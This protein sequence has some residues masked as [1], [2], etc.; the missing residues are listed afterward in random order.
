MIGWLEKL[1]AGEIL[2]IDGGTGSELQ[3]R[4]VAMDRNAW[5]GPAACTHKEVLRQIHTDYI[6]AGAQIITTNTFGTTRFVLEAAGLGD[7]F[8]KINKS[9]IDAAQEGREDADGEHVAIAG[10]LSCLPPGLNAETYP[11][12]RK[13]KGGYQELAE[14]L[15][16]SGVDLIALEMMEDNYHSL[17][18][19]EAAQEVGLPL[20]LGVSSRF[21]PDGKSLVAFD[22]PD[23]SFSSVLQS[24]I[25]LDPLVVNIMHTEPNVVPSA[26]KN[27]KQYWTGPIGV[28]PEL[29]DFSAPNWVFNNLMEPKHFAEHALQWVRNGARLLGGCC[30]TTPKHIQILKNKMSD[31]LAART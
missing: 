6:R 10:S 9:T 27:L 26:L 11:S 29:G 24:L 4:G 17:M 18:A 21:G 15:A 22:F 1:N 7:E 28:Y 25:S 12:K 30:G 13:E 20:W 14:F 31:L 3:R 8:R 19:M 2:L 23:T 16:E 5:S